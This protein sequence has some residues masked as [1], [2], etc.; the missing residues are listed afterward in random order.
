MS[1][2]PQ[3]YHSIFSLFSLCPDA[4][5]MVAGMIGLMNLV[6][7]TAQDIPALLGMSIAFFAI[8]AASP[9]VSAITMM[10]FYWKDDSV[11]LGQFFWTVF[12]VTSSLFIALSAFYCDWCLGLMLGDLSGAPA[13]DNAPFYWTYFAAKRFSMFSW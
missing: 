12:V 13:S 11:S 6:A 10:K 7:K 4:P 8:V 2:Q 5:G 9:F 3:Y 1:I